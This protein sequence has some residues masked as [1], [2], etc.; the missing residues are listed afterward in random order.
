MKKTLTEHFQKPLKN[1]SVIITTIIVLAFYGNLQQANGQ[2]ML[3]K[4]GSW[5]SYTY[6]K[7]GTLTCYMYTKP[8]KKTGN[9]KKR[10]E[11]NLMVTRRSPNAIE[12]V[13][14]T[15]G[16]PYKKGVPVKI[17]ID[18]KKINFRLIENEHAWADSPEQDKAM[19]KAMI[20]GNKLVVRGT[21]RKG[22]YS[23]DSYTLKGF[24]ASYKA[25]VKACPSN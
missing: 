24:T 16:Y 18:G 3:S 8:V 17:N 7:G 20:K 25:I 1:L 6:E 22:T 9:Y 19:I 4:N 14:I 15:S 2:K 12:E 13:S 5:A 10:D 11:P 23:Q 21:S